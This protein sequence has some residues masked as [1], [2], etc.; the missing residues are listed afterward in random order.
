MIPTASKP[1]LR[2]L[3]LVVAAGALLAACGGDDDA[4]EA[5][6]GPE[7]TEA[8]ADLARDHTEDPVEYP[9]SPP[10]G[11]A[12]SP[13]WQNCGVYRD[14]VNNEN[15]VHVL[16][17]GGVWIAYAEDLPA[18]DIETLESKAAGQSYILVTPYE[19]LDDPVVLTAWG[20]QLRLNSVDDP[21]VDEFIETFQ[22]GPQTPEPGSPCTGGT[23]DPVAS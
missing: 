20:R 4:A 9:Q 5:P 22:E 10:V 16:E 12:H 6:A 7:G 13:I 3:A 8:F 18:A 2:A 14:P 19:D 17:H 15:A 21:R 23:G 1:W 11:G